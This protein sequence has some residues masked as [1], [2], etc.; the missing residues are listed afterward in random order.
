MARV[1]NDLFKKHRFNV[2][3]FLFIMMLSSVLCTDAIGQVQVGLS[4]NV[5]NRQ[6]YSTSEGFKRALAPS[7][8]LSI[9]LYNFKDKTLQSV[10]AV[11]DY[12]I[13]IQFLY[14]PNY[15]ITNKLTREQMRMYSEKEP[16]DFTIK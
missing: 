7:G 13:M 6:H 4:L 16:I 1:I 3:W 2:R 11:Y 9:N 10:N 14:R 15:Q 12:P 8:S 5:G